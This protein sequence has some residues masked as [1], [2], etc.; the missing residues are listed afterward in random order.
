MVEVFTLI[1]GLAAM[2]QLA[3]SVVE[4][5]KELRVCVRTIRSA[6]KEIEYF[7]L[8]TYI[9]TNLLCY[10]HEVAKGSAAVMNENPKAKRAR[11]RGFAYLVRRFID[12]KGADTA[13]LNTLWARLLC[14]WK[15]LD[16]PELHLNLQSAI[17]N[18]QYEPTMKPVYMY[19]AWLNALVRFV[20][21]C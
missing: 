1:G 10:F 13:S 8:Q 2:M 9:F 20:F 6:P 5:T 18:S 11:M 4:L 3:G 19:V 7:I 21:N 17:A 14:L 15:R 16:V 12:I